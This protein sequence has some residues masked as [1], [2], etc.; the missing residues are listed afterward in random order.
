MVYDGAPAASLYG[1]DIEAAFKSLGYDLL[2]DERKLQSHFIV[3]DL[4]DMDLR[5]IR[6]TMDV[7][8]ASAFFH[9]FSRAKQLVIVQTLISVLRPQPG[10][11]IIGAHLGCTYPAEYELSLGGPKS[12]RHSPES[13]AQ[14]WEEAATLIETKWKVECSIDTIGMVGNEHMGWA[15]PI[16]RRLVYTVTMKYDPRTKL[17]PRHLSCLFRLEIA[18]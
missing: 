5:D 17:F 1:I 12:F 10:S 18:H 16:M 14:L 11:M 6:E 4:I 9:L 2:L 3:G 8:V 7:V 15:E 13:F